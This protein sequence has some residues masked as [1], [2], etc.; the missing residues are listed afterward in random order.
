MR[1]VVA[2]IT[3]LLILSP[4]ALAQV[5]PQIT[6]SDLTCVSPAAFIKVNVNVAVPSGE[7]IDYVR[8]YF[9]TP[10]AE[11]DVWFFVAA[12]PA[13]DLWAATLPA[14]VP[15]AGMV[16]YRS[17]VKLL[18][19]TTALTEI[20]TVKIQEECEVAMMEGNPCEEASLIIG[21]T[22]PEPRLP[23]GFQNAG[24]DGVVT[25]EMTMVA[26]STLTGWDVDSIV[27]PAMVPAG[28]LP[29][30]G[31]IVGGLVGAGI[32]GAIID[33]QNRDEDVSPN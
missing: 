13:G 12:A 26:A 22:A 3:A 8:T 21:T 20:E 15:E 25:E 29:R 2:T 27:C 24:I 7:A 9:R 17:E 23:N 16:M 11:E 28:G 31:L 33:H 14:P 18:N 30:A 10:L 1:R 6:Q 32:I 5:R 4:A 19:G